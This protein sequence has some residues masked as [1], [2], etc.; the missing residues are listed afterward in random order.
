MRFLSRLAAPLLA[1]ALI[2]AAPALAQEATFDPGQTEAIEKI[3]HD[4]LLEHPEVIR[5]AIQALQAKEEAAKADQQASALA[6]HK[7][8]L[9]NDPGSPVAGNAMG[10]VT[11][12]EFFDYKCPYCKRVTPA[13]TELLA[14]DKGVRLVFKEFPILGESSLLAA[15]AALAAKQQ[16]RYLEFHNALMAQRGDF[17]MAAIEGIAKATGVDFAKLSADMKAPEVDQQ[18]RDTHELAIALG[19]RS[20]PTFIVGDEI[21]PGAISI[22]DMKALIA[23]FRSGS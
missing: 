1:V 4:Y 9:L 22:D 12:V 16:D 14:A 2:G 11:I 17:D 21:V 5:D 3:V 23:D 7:D 10:D 19:I 15:R 13:L 18:L 6:Q 20:T 8:R